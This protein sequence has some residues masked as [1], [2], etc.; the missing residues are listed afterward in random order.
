MQISKEKYDVIQVYL[1][2]LGSDGSGLARE[3]CCEQ[4]LNTIFFFNLFFK[5]KHFAIFDVFSKLKLGPDHVQVFWTHKCFGNIS[6]L[7]TRP[8]FG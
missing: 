3:T 7:E 6:L 5:K 4:K 2:K 1:K 8:Q